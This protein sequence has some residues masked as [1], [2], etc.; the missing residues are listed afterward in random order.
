MTDSKLCPH[1]IYWNSDVLDFIGHTKP[2]IIKVVAPFGHN[3]TMIKDAKNRSPD[4]RWLLR[5]YLNEQPLDKPKERATWLVEKV[6]RYFDYYD[7][8]EDYNEPPPFGPD[9]WKRY[10]EFS[11]EFSRILASYGK[12]TVTGCWS[13]GQP[14]D[15]AWEY[16]KDSVEW[17]NYVSLHGY[18]WPTM[19]GC[20][21]FTLRYRHIYHDLLP[22]DRPLILS[23]MGMT[24]AVFGGP[25]LGWISWSD[26]MEH[27]KEGRAAAEWAWL[28]DRL[29]E[30]P[31]VISAHA[32][33]TGRIPGDNWGTHDFTPRLYK[34][35]G[36]YILGHPSPPPQNNYRTV[37]EPDSGKEEVK[38][39]I[40][41]GW[42]KVPENIRRW[43][44]ILSRE[45][46]TFEH[47]II[48]YAGKDLCVDRIGA[49]IIKIESGGDPK[50]VGGAGHAHGLMQVWKD[51]YPALDLFDPTVNTKTGLQILKSKLGTAKG[52]LKD[53]LYYYSGG[54]AWASIEGYTQ[55][56]WQPFARYYKE[57]FGDDLGL[58]QKENSE[59]EKQLQIID[60]AARVIE[61][62]VAKLREQKK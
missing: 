18:G 45:Q 4:S 51:D 52:N 25:D 47:P 13:N 38:M 14:P 53:A 5:F 42:E 16:L 8:F 32:Y 19:S 23:E 12:Q 41:Q 44:P 31:F 37:K 34:L 43:Y 15:E 56:Y 21:Q 54:T 24:N 29:N 61:N 17:A 50:A 39:T 9:D 57:W 2:A 55:T 11:A 46:W 59:I 7:I 33:T 60:S 27:Q 28:L 1:I 35:V 6:K 58:S 10:N 36:D 62:A 30:D 22:F 48:K 26:V 49:C 20:P 40:P 3:E